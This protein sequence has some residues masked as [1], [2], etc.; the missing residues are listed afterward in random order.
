MPS[1]TWKLIALLTLIFAVAV[2]LWMILLGPYSRCDRLLSQVTDART[3]HG[4]REAQLR[5]MGGGCDAAGIQRELDNHDALME[6]YKAH[7][8]R[9]SFGSGK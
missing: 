4:A 7:P 6:F 1:L 9:Y 2:F 5:A 3:L 8:D